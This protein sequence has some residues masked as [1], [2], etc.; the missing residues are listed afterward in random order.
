MKDKIL[1]VLKKSKKG[2]TLTQLKVQVGIK[3]KGKILD[4]EFSSFVKSG[5]AVKKG[6]RYYLKG[7]T[8]LIKGRF[9][10]TNFGYGFVITPK[11]DFFIPRR[12]KKDAL[13][14]DIVEAIVSGKKRE[15]KIIRVV[16]RKRKKIAG[17]FVWERKMPVVIP[18]ERKLPEIEVKNMPVQP[19]RQGDVVEAALSGRKCIVKDIIGNPKDPG[20]D[21]KA[22]LI[23]YEIPVKFSGAKIKEEEEKI[24]RK[25]LKNE[26]IFTIDGETAKD[27]DDAVSIKKTKDG[28]SIGIHIADVSHYVQKG[29]ALDKEARKRGNSVYFPESAIPMLP[30]L[31][32]ENLS[33]LKPQEDRYTITVEIHINR[34]GKVKGY[35]IYPSII[36]S[37][38]RMT[39]KKVWEILQ[40]DSKLRSKYSKIV[41]QIDMMGEAAEL[42]LSQRRKRG[43]I[44][45]DLPEP[46]FIYTSDGML[47][48]ILPSKRNFAHQI[49]EEFML[50]ANEAVAR[51]LTKRKYPTIYRIH[52]AP[53]KRKLESLDKALR[54]FGYSLNFEE[55]E[56]KALQKILELAEGKRE[57]KLINLL[58][59]R[60]MK[61]AKYSP[62]SS[63]HFALS[64]EHYLH[65]TSPIRR[66]PDLVVHRVLKA[67]IGK[68]NPPYNEKELEKIAEHSSMTERRAAQVE[69]EIALWRTARFLQKKIGEKFEGTIVGITNDGLQ[70]ELDKYLI[71]GTVLF[72]EMKQDYFIVV[73]GWIAR[74]KRSGKSYRVGERVNVTLGSVDPYRR[75]IYLFPEERK[76]RKKKKLTLS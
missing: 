5:L 54:I 70:I 16:E 52:E 27:F 57:E 62:E 69:A 35:K 39:Y 68:E 3:G 9:E 23:H 59:L 40:G 15:G 47:I 41:P 36:I 1:E 28:F 58:I 65:F 31:L 13:H 43:S 30:P 26:I 4:R 75:I 50:A 17:F 21:I 19:I 45:F 49:I 14:G 37:K 67:A 25:N 73:D 33:S 6:N 24:E 7:D 63:G 32:S 51:Y 66:Y 60:S 61:L 34:T 46:D 56:A 48:D 38:E 10:N 71:Q 76:R 42:L 74:G 2:I 22:L 55:P 8:N 64:K 72:S 53:D 12:F 18:V 44:D 29:T 11:G 20:V